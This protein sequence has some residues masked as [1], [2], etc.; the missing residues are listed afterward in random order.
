VKYA[1]GIMTALITALILTIGLG[2]GL[3]LMPLMVIIG[4]GLMGYGLAEKYI[5]TPK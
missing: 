2:F 3:G 5:G 4:L 1:V